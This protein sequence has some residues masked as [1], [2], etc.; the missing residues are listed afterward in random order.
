MLFSSNPGEDGVHDLARRA[1]CRTCNGRCLRGAA[2]DAPVEG[3][4]EPAGFPE[5]CHGGVAV[6]LLAEVTVGT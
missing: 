2:L 5:S 3:P 1:A 4:L 6:A